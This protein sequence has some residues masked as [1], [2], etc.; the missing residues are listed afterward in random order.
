MSAGYLYSGVIGSR[1]RA[2]GVFVEAMRMRLCWDELK[3]QAAAIRKGG[4]ETRVRVHTVRPVKERV[5]GVCRTHMNH[6]ASKPSWRPSHSSHRR[7][8][9]RAE[10][11]PDLVL[12]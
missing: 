5:R 4:P 9:A 12:S 3:R 11:R 10:S 1:L 7:P 8:P 2:R 6:I